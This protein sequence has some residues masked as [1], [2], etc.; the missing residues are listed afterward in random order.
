MA[1]GT[2]DGA[3]GGR[4]DGAFVFFDIETTGLSPR[5]DGIIEI[6][7]LRLSPRQGLKESFQ[8]LVRI[9]RPVPAIITRM[10]GISDHMLRDQDPIDTILPR[11][12]DFVR[13]VPLVAYNVQFDMGFLKA[14]ARRMG[15]EVPNLSICALELARRRLPRLPNHKLAT[16]AS[17]LG[18]TADQTHRALDDCEMGLRVFETL[19]KR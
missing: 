15:R 4:A 9:D 17:H 10:T 6:A 14:A 19:M 7:G 1:S 3:I 16:V 13:D 2:T 12:L 11:F 5:T 18:V 8:A